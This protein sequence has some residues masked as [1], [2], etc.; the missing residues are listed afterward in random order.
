MTKTVFVVGAGA[1]FEFGLPLGSTLLDDIWKQ[2]QSVRDPITSPSNDK[3]DLGRIIAHSSGITEAHKNT[4]ERLQTAL[5]FALSIDRLLDQRAEEPDLVEMGK[6]AIAV[7]IATA[8]RRSSLGKLG[9]QKTGQDHLRHPLFEDRTATTLRGLSPTWLF[10]V[11]QMLGERLGPKTIG[12][13]FDELTFVTFNYD[14]CIEQYLYFTLVNAWHVPPADAA[15]IVRNNVRVLHVYGDLGRLTF[16]GVQ[17]TGYGVV[18]PVLLGAASRLRTFTE[19]IDTAWLDQIRAT[20]AD[21]QHVVF[22]GFSF[23][24]RNCKL[25]FADG[26]P[27]GASLWGTMFFPGDE[28]EQL[29]RARANL[30]APGHYEAHRTANMRE[31]PAEEFIRRLGPALFAR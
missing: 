20:L 7:A 21:A 8:E 30:F 17:P 26:P 11:M 19:Q 18:D 13:A 10:R 27:P 5:T 14:R 28:G 3:Y 2:L 25:L 24:E 29:D 22:L 1:S 16:H 6:R 23:E 31:K 9:M 4:A 12:S 15:E